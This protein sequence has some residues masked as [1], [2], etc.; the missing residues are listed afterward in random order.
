MGVIQLLGCLVE[1]QPFVGWWDMYSFLPLRSTSRRTFFTGLYIITLHIP[2]YLST[3]TI[4]SVHLTHSD[5]LSY[6]AAFKVRTFESLVEKLLKLTWKVLKEN[7]IIDRSWSSAKLFIMQN[8]TDNA[9]ENVPLTVENVWHFW[10]LWVQD[11]HMFFCTEK[12]SPMIYRFLYKNDFII[13]RQN[14]D[15]K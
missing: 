12:Q 10:F 4:Y 13:L 7:S 6:S 2:C 1:D 9:N 15:H 11:A 14:R 5:I 3:C 8:Y